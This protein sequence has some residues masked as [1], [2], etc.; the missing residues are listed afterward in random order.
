MPRT[1]KLYARIHLSKINIIFTVTST[2]YAPFIVKPK[3]KYIMKR[4]FLLVML[5]AMCGCIIS[6]SKSK[7]EPVVNLDEIKAN[8]QAMEDQYAM[9]LNQRTADGVT[10]YADDAVSFPTEQK[11]LHGKTAILEAVQ[12][13]LT[14]V[15]QGH[16]ITFTTKEVHLSKDGGQLVEVGEYILTDQAF[17]K[18]RSGNFISVFQKQEDGKYKC[19]RDIATPDSPRPH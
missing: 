14:E 4:K 1:E 11:P 16:K 5:I 12:K 19:F 17:K 13:D 7:A 10:Y 2:N 8:I 15:P 3:T 6:C 18:V 9:Q